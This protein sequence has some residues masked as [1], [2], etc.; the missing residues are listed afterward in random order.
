MSEF[1]RPKM[2]VSTQTQAIF[3][4]PVRSASK[5]ISRLKIPKKVTL[6]AAV[7]VDLGK[8]QYRRCLR[9]SVAVQTD[10]ELRTGVGSQV[11]FNRDFATDVGSQVSLEKEDDSKYL[12]ELEMQKKVNLAIA[13]LCFHLSQ[14]NGIDLEGRESVDEEEEEERGKKN[15][16]EK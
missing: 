7:Q 10:Q 8:E 3:L 2:E 11:N 1:V 14:K 13:E 9:E 16:K 15:E 4:T 5:Y 12:E 6:N